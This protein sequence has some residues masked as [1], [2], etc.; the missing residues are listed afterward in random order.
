MAKRLK[1]PS[2]VRDEMQL[3]LS[4]IIGESPNWHNHFGKLTI[5]F[6][7]KVTYALWPTRV[8]LVNTQ[9]NVYKKAHNGFIH[10]NSRRGKSQMPVIVSLVNKSCYIHMMKKII[11]AMKKNK[12]FYKQKCGCI[13]S[14][15]LL[16][17][18]CFTS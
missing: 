7:T 14:T 11:Q 9:E 12:L 15:L 4:F 18:K 1:I 17:K 6:K 5:S 2:V 16:I 13:L 8:F 3:R 10:N